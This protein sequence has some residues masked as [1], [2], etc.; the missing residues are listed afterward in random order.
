MNINK[1]LAR[2]LVLAL[3]V[4]V[5]IISLTVPTM[6]A[7][8]KKDEDSY[9]H[10]VS[11]EYAPLTDEEREA[12]IREEMEK[13]LGP[14]ADYCMYFGDED[15]NQIMPM[16]DIDEYKTEY[17]PTK[18]VSVSGKPGGVLEASLSV[19]GPSDQTYY[20]GWT[21]TDAGGPTVSKG[22][23][24]AHPFNFLTVS[25]SLGMVSNTDKYG[26]EFGINDAKPGVKYKVNKVT[27]TYDVVKYI[28]YTKRYDDAG[29]YTWHEWSGGK[30]ET[31]TNRDFN[32]V[33]A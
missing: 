9:E 14:D 29:N 12:Y 27:K 10:T 4:S 3:L 28:I 22:I 13:L 32:I 19:S 6:A 17:S 23:S 20:L 25:F 15:T 7:E 2:K 18:S 1:Y 5:V 26:I 8:E 30:I 21:Y 16:N 24:F 11:F 33:R 31:L